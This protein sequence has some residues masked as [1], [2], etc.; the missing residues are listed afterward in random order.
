MKQEGRT[1]SLSGISD[2]EKKY[3]IGVDFGTD[4]VR[5]VVADLEDGSTRASGVAFYPRWKKGLYQHPDRAVYRQHPRDYLEALEEA[6]KTAVQKLT[7]KEREQVGGIGVD[8]TGSTPAPADRNGTILALKEDM[9]EEEGAM[10][11]LWK[12]HAAL[13]EAAEVNRAF[14]GGDVDFC[15]YMGYYSSEWFWAKIL[16][17]VR[18][19]PE[20]RERAWI[21]IEHCDWIVGVLSGNTDPETMYHS[22][23]G[24][25]HKGYWH[26][27]WGGFPS[28]E[29]L[30]SLDPY[31]VE[32]KHRFVRRPE[33]SV[34]AVGRIAS[35]W[36]EKLGLPGDVVISGSSLDS[37][38]GAVGAG[39]RE[40]TLVCILGTSACDMMVA[41]P[42][43]MEGKVIRDHAGQ[44]E[45]SILPGYVGIESGQSAFGDL[46]AW[47]RDLLLWPVRQ[48][49]RE[50][51]GAGVLEKE[52]LSWLTREAEKLPSE[53]FPIAL[54]WINGRRYPV[55]DDSRKAAVSGLSLAVGAPCLYR[56]LVFA[57]LCGLKRITDGMEQAGLEIDC[58][59]AVGG[60]PGKSPFIM[61][62]LS[63]LLNKP[64]EVPDDQQ[65]SALGAAVYAAVACGRY[66]SAEEAVSHMT[67]H[68]GSRYVPDPEKHAFYLEKF[69]QYLELA[70]REDR[71]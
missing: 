15:T 62:M 57:A 9:A 19:Q 63:D 25:G 67:A 30:A 27:A 12:E 13:E 6:L 46:F 60:I 23:C 44:A 28:D 29:V 40:K 70:G 31:L 52:L 71:V 66:K 7:P 26:S 39:I 59:K 18:V 14:M 10:F 58:V 47:F 69:G 36:A 53:P 11:Y 68:D 5:A 50:P 20:L 34:T 51:D 64:V 4:S 45:D 54:D 8:T 22:A 35:E 2:M 17:A 49:T 61:Q 55:T 1:D 32:V 37:H 41:R 24:T 3:V 42:S 16:H 43:F 33:S 38:A 56:S 48:M 21:W 65:T